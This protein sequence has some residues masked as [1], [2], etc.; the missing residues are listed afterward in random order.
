V[1]AVDCPVNVLAAAG[2]PTVAELGR[3]GVAR[4]PVGGAFAFTASD[5][6]TRAGTE[7]LNHGTYDFRVRAAAGQNAARQAFSA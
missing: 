6:L 7:L 4:I 2:V 1:S 3:L 5:A